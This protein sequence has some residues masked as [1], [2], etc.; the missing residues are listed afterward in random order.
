MDTAS[1]AGVTVAFNNVNKLYFRINA[2]DITGVTVTVTI[3]G[4]ATTYTNADFVNESDGVYGLYTEA[5]K[6]TQFDEEVTAVMSQGE[7]QGQTVTYGVKAYV[8]VMQNGG[9]AMAELA[10]ATYKYGVS[11][12]AYQN[13]Q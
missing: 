4:V 8:Y 6:A 10:K 9:N 7:T 12:V 1:F 13:A 11:A 3:G 2:T 5:I